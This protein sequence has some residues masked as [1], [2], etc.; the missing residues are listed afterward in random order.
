MRSDHQDSTSVWGD[1][2]SV[3]I[4]SWLSEPLIPGIPLDK[5]DTLDIHIHNRKGWSGLKGTHKIQ[6]G[7][8]DSIYAEM[9]LMEL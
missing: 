2:N 9:L 1:H 4:W 3:R 8:E 6:V 5:G 7:K